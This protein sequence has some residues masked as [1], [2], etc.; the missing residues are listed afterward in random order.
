MSCSRTLP[1]S[2]GVEIVDILI[3]IL[4][5]ARP[6]KSPADNTVIPLPYESQREQSSLRGFRPGPTQTGLYNQRSKLES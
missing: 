5:P 1:C 6:Q 2:Y 4:M 3:Q